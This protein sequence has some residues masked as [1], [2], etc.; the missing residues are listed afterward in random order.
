MTWRALAGALCLLALPAAGGAGGAPEAAAP[1]CVDRAVARVQERYEG[2]RSLRARFVQTTHSVALGA[3]R[4]GAEN[5]S[6]G[7]V[8]FA[9]P[10]R[11]RWSY[12][13]PEPSLVVSDGSTLWVYDPAR[14]EAHRLPVGAGFL[15]GAAIQ[16]LLGEG[17]IRDSFRVTSLSCETGSSRLE[18][19]PRE[20]ASYERLRLRIDAA[21]G[22]V[23]HTEMVDLLGNRTEVAFEGIEV[24]FSP[25]PASFRFE[26]PEG[27]R[28][29]DLGAAAEGSEG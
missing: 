5:R 14:R 4:P 11:M 24:D 8:S 18:L 7:R 16:F 25:P 22:D 29:I 13:E 6:S 17:D 1:D 27:V 26:P 19:V 2:V 12:E 23:V 15:S 21:S 28:V 3:G 9:K 10:G 20:P